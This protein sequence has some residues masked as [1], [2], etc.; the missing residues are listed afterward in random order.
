MDTRNYFSTSIQSL[1]SG[2]VFVEDIQTV[3]L[4][5][6]SPAILLKNYTNK[7]P[8]TERLVGNKEVSGAQLEIKSAGS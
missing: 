8:V 5:V 4:S 2:E 3:D 6:F 7:L 1:Q